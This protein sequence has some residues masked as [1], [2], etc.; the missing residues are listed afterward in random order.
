[1]DPRL[2]TSV[3]L[4]GCRVRVNSVTNQIGIMFM[5]ILMHTRKSMK[6]ILIVD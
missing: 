6:K 4:S 3:S 2:T 5:A 1:M